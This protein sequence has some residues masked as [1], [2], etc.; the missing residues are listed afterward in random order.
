MRIVATETGDSPAV[1]HALHEIVALHAILVRGA[2]REIVKVGLVQ[3][4]VFKFPEILKLKANVIP[5]GPVVV[6]P[7]DRDGQ[8]ASLRMALDA[9]IACRNVI[10]A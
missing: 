10:H 5:D 1:H 9:S 8:R 4:M 2:V 6:P 7:L 3:R